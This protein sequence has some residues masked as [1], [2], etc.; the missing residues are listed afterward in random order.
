M[1]LTFELQNQFKIEEKKHEIITPGSNSNTIRKNKAM[2]QE[3][4]KMI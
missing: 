2:E 3:I 1:K 4:R